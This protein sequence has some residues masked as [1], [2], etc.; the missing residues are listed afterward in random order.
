MTDEVVGGRKCLVNDIFRVVHD[1]FGHIKD[2]SGFSDDGEENAWRA[3]AAMFSPLA[4]GALTSE[5]RGQA[6]WVNYGPHGE[7]NRTASAADITYA[8][9]KIGLMPEWTYN[10]GWQDPKARDGWSSPRFGARDAEF[11]EADHPR[12]DDGKFTEGGSAGGKI[13]D[14][15]REHK[16]FAKFFERGA[17]VPR[18]NET[19]K[20]LEFHPKPHPGIV[21][22]HSGREDQPHKFSYYDPRYAELK[23]IGEDEPIIARKIAVPK[24][25]VNEEIEPLDDP[26]TIYRGMS[27]EEY[28]NIIKSGEVESKGTHNIGEG[29]KGLTYWTTD[30]RMADS[31][32]NGFAPAEF[33]P[34]F[35]HPAYVIATKRPNETR[36]V[37]GTD[38]REVGVARSVYATRS[39]ASGVAIRTNMIQ[40][41][42]VCRAT[43]VM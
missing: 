30:P 37:A 42:I 36:K 8:P 29:Q 21:R 6:S 25:D 9:Q 19:T 20:E 1:Y 17:T 34:T 2:G 22:Y 11:K 41:A 31:Y 27:S 3:H 38:A 14:T 39:P 12:D 33:K 16:Y 10:E 24:S 13:L 23:T 28:D 18:V 4:R 15:V 32:A 40:A 43:R 7:T 5:T 35:T 26:D